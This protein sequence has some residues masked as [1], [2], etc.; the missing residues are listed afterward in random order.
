MRS[1]QEV[2]RQDKLVVVAV[3]HL[4]DFL[5]LV[6]AVLMVEL[7]VDF[8][9]ENMASPAGEEPELENGLSVLRRVGLHN[10][11]LLTPDGVLSLGKRGVD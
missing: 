2:I 4:N 5:E 1:L 6:A 3:E 8:K 9:L 11:V 10:Q 7:H